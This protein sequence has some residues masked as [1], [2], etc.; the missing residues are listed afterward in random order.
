MRS[1]KA[2]GG[3]QPKASIT[4]RPAPARVM[5]RSR[6]PASRRGAPSGAIH[7]QRT[8][9]VHPQPH[10]LAARGQVGRQAPA[11]ADVADGCRSPGRRG[12]RAPVHCMPRLSKAAQLAPD[13]RRRADPRRLCARHCLQ[14][15]ERLLA[16]VAALPGLPGVY[17]YFDAQGEVLYV[18]KARNLKKRVSSY[19]HKNHGG[20]RIGHMVDAH[21]AAGDHGGAHRSRSAAAREQ[22]D[23]DAEPEVT[24]SCFATTRVT[25]T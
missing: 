18:G 3:S 8:G 12:P 16:E 15:R 21:R 14:A 20:T 2:V 17:R 10:R 25:R 6:A 5:M 24:T 19:F 23:Q 9:I 4:P 7:C 1:T 11:H 13:E 22:P